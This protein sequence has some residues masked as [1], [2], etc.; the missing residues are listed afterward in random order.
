[1]IN[2]VMYSEKLNLSELEKA[3][4]ILAAHFYRSTSN[5]PMRKFYKEER[6]KFNKDPRLQFET[7][8]AWD[9]EVRS[10]V[11]CAQTGISGD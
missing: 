4:R 10:S 5:N 3:Y 8:E 7:I 6:D 9:M 11:R 1:M 2:V